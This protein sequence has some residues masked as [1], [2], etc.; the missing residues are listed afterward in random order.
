MK[1]CIFCEYC[2][3][4]ICDQSCPSYVE[5]S[6]LLERNNIATSNSVFSR[7]TSAIAEYS[8]L[9]EK[10]SGKIK[11]VQTKM[12]TVQ[13]ADMLTYCAC[14]KYFRGS[15]LNTVVYNL[16]YAWYI[17]AIKQSWSMKEEPSDLQYAKIWSSTTETLII[18]GMDYVNFG[19]FECQTLLQLLQQR[20]SKHKTTFLIIPEIRQL[21][22]KGDFF[23]RLKNYLEQAVRA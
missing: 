17:D 19:D 4:T 9:L 3:D 12:S 23:L 1:D 18:S 10:H 20:E 13:T 16:K 2:R 8:T 22:G 11:A 14:C 7:S 5:M 21:I 6:F 15:R